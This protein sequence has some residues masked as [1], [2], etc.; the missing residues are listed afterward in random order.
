MKRFI[1]PFLLLCA[2]PSVSHG[3]SDPVG[4]ARSAS[5]TLSEA[6][7]QLQ[8][9]K[10]SK[11]R[12]GALTQTIR[13]YEQGLTA[14]REGVRRAT[15]KERAISLSF[16]ERSDRLSRLLGALQTMEKSNAPLLMMHPNGPIGTARSG[17]ILSEV[18]PSLQA[19]ASE[20]KTQL[21]ELALLRALQQSA[22]TAL[23]DGLT[24][25]QEARTEL[26]VAIAERTDLPKS[27]T[28]DPDQLRLLLE[29]SDT[30]ESFADGLVEIATVDAPPEVEFSSVKG[31]LPPP[32]PGVLLH[33][34]NQTDAAGIK[35][36]GWVWATQSLTLITTPWPATIRY[37]GPLLNYGNVVILEPQE[38]Y[39]LILAGMN[40]TFGE[41]GQVV[42][43]DEPIGI[44]G[45][46]PPNAD[47]FLMDTGKGS[48]GNRRESL[49]IELRQ[50]GAPVDPGDWFTAN[51][52]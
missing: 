12:I 3:Q 6:A 37:R 33:G 41:V 49:Y 43:K 26:S 20:L 16:E 10:R 8:N 50:D 40:Q 18:A 4:L 46:L 25:V 34:F 5:E 32:G 2:F 24:G 19:Q 14:L 30:L 35:R 45:G 15:I 29:N 23:Q 28:S 36:P 44:M 22:A 48:G 31:T 13:G 38:G 39:L 52:E 42:Y 7:S 51:E 1:L 27:F 17:M 11:D 9:A 47:A 21:E